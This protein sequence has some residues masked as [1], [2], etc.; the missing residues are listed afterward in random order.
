MDDPTGQTSKPGKLQFLLRRILARS[1]AL[2]RGIVALA[3]ELWREIRGAHLPRTDRNR[4]L[5]SVALALIIHGILFLLVPGPAALEPVRFEAPL[6]V[7]F[8]PLPEERA[9]EPDPPPPPPPPSPPPPPP[10]P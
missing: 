6:Y 8:D 2:V 1:V 9:L 7:S 4:L 5:L 10:P 3:K